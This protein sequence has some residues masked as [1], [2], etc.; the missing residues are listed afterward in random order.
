MKIIQKKEF[1]GRLTKRK[2]LKI[3]FR[4]SVFNNNKY[5]KNMQENKILLK[6][7][8]IKAEI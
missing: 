6:N 1:C 3:G 2:I 5:C 4:P 7:S 8:Q